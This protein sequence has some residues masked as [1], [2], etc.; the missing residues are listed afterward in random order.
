M[1][2]QFWLQSSSP[3]LPT[4]AYLRVLG[5]H[6]LSAT[7]IDKDFNDGFTSDLWSLGSKKRLMR[8]GISREIFT[9]DVLPRDT[10][11]PLFIATGWHCPTTQ[12]LQASIELI[13]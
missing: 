3:L 12:W 11:Q 2:S 4:E 5:T 6:R 1:A 10:V 7:L 13:V 8:A 9:V